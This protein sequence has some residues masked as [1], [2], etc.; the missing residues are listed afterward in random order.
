MWYKHSFGF[1]ELFWLSEK[2]IVLSQVTR[3]KGEPKID[4]GTWRMCS[5]SLIKSFGSIDLQFL[6]KI[7]YF[8]LR[9]WCCNAQ[10]WYGMFLE[11]SSNYL[12]Q[13]WKL[14]K[15]QDQSNLGW[16]DD[17]TYFPF[18][19]QIQTNQI[20]SRTEHPMEG[21]LLALAIW[22]RSHP[23]CRV[24]RLCHCARITVVNLGSGSQELWEKRHISSKKLCK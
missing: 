20:T 3:G 17:C 13:F 6:H 22:L 11:H 18:F 19:M 16:I 1:H 2:W 15:P 12:V 8:T 5:R 10:H 9:N 21:E 7:W 14:R 24:F 4:Q 23:L